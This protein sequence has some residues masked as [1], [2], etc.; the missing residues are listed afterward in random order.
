MSHRYPSTIARIAAAATLGLLATAAGAQYST[1]VRDVENPARTRFMESGLVTMDP[2]NVGN[3]DD[4]VVV[5]AGK[6]MVIEQA[7]VRCWQDDGN[8]VTTRIVVTHVSAGSSASIN[9]DIPLRYQGVDPF[10]GRIFVGSMMTRLYADAGTTVKGWATRDAGI[11]EAKCG[12]AISG[13][14]IVP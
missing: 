12:F 7:S 1:P 2:N 14:T 3:A 11:G 13:H 9:F 6:R 5:P 4:I 8:I 10:N